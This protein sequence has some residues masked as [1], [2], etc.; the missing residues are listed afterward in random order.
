MATINSPSTIIALLKRAKAAY[1]PA[2]PEPKSKPELRHSDIT[3]D[4]QRLQE[5]VHKKAGPDGAKLA[6][7]FNARKKVLLKKLTEHRKKINSSAEK[8][9]D[10]NKAHLPAFT[11]A[12]LK[13]TTAVLRLDFASATGD[14]ES[15]NLDGLEE[16]DLAELD[17]LDQLS[18][19]DVA[20]LE[21]ES[22]EQAGVDLAP[23][24]APMPG[25]SPP[26]PPSGPVVIKRLLAINSEYT[27]A[28]AKPGPH[29]AILQTQHNK[30]K[31]A[32]DAKDFA[33][34]DKAIDGLRRSWAGFTSWRRMCLRRPAP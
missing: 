23:T 27:T 34:A 13:I 28:I 8:N 33:A 22:G 21:R 9:E 20:A 31:E 17:K 3:K 24:V 32:L 15:A 12:L 1:Q 10:A 7:P 19:E 6:G 30:V 18:D 11:K 5:I 29:V 4:L 16:G 25:K 14:E 26:P 2:K